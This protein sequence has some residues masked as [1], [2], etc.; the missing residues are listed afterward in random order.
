MV[1]YYISREQMTQITDEIVEVVRD[2]AADFGLKYGVVVVSYDGGACFQDLAMGEKEIHSFT[3][4]LGGSRV[5]PPEATED[6][7]T[8]DCL[9]VAISKINALDKAYLCSECRVLVS[10]QG[11]DDDNILG[12]QNWG[13]CVAYPMTVDGKV[14]FGKIMVAVSGGT[15][16]QDADCAWAAYDVVRSI[17]T[18][19]T[20]NPGKTAY[21]S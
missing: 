1:P 7:F 17:P 15:S 11:N 14:I 5:L 9:G 12:R 16:E 19:H 8:C 4:D 2:K 13:G 21:F 3:L 20:T 10:E 6:G 18:C